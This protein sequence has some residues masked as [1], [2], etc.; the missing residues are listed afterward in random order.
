MKYLGKVILGIGNWIS[1]LSNRSRAILVAG[2]LLL[3]LGG[4][5]NK[6]IGALNRPREAQPQVSP[7]QIIKPMQ[8]LFKQVSVPRSDLRIEK[9]LRRLD[10]LAT[11]YRTK[12]QKT[13]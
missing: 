12:Q 7:D 8:Q 13:P 3:L 6:L 5:V 10:S 1:G 4:S 9:D 11:E 2:M